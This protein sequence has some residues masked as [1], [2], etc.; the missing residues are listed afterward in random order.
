MCSK[1]TLC[2]FCCSSLGWPR[3]RAFLLC[4]RL[5]DVAECKI[6]HL[7]LL[8]APSFKA[9]EPLKLRPINNSLRP[10]NNSAL[11]PINNSALRPINNSLRPINIRLRPINNSLRPILTS[12]SDTEAVLWRLGSPALPHW[13]QVPG[14]SLT[15]LT[16]I[17]LLKENTKTCESNECIH[18][19]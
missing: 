13:S 11:R 8:L 9:L 1:T 19:H 5:L 4:W 10:I 6:Q 17:A 12:D 7:M 16:E 3:A 18:I 14:A 2:L 15:V